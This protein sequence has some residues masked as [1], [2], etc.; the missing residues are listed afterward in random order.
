MKQPLLIFILLM[1]TTVLWTQEIK[2]LNP[3]IELL[4]F[5]K[6]GEQ[7]YLIEEENFEKAYELIENGKKL[8]ELPREFQEAYHNFDEMSTYWG[9]GT[10]GCS[11]YCGASI[12]MVSASSYLKT[13]GKTSY[14]PKNAHDF[15]YKNAWVEGVDGYGVGE[16][17]EFSFPQENPRITQIS[18]VNGYVKS[19]KAWRENSRVKKLKMYI[20]DVPYAILNLKDERATNHFEVAPIGNADR[21]NYEE[22]AKLPDWTMKFEIL[23]VYRGEKYEDTVISEI[24]FDGI[25]VHC[26]AAGTM[27]T[28]TDTTQKPIELLKIGDEVVSYDIEAK[29]YITAVIEEVAHPIHSN[30]VTI[31]FDDQSEIICTDD[32]PLLIANGAWVS[33]NPSKTIKDYDY[34]QVHQ[35]KIGD[36]LQGNDKQQTVAS[37]KTTVEAQPTYTIVRLDKGTNFIANNIVV[38]TEPLRKKINCD[39][40]QSKGNVS[41]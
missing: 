1:G 20:D 29:T 24:Y 27:I 6:E 15:D 16:F 30:L 34:D 10:D 17:L 21:N 40:H 39:I 2:T 8:E 18:I 25:D 31:I 3:N 32:H 14:V 33:Y 28:M 5:S 7:S 11:W 12:A 36:V 23:E 19:E 4:E 13:Q 37:I 35:L 26:F 22:L 9:I 41:K 38:G